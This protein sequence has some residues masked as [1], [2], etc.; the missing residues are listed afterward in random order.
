[1]TRPA[2]LL[3]GTLYE[4]GRAL[5]LA[6]VVSRQGVTRSGRK[7]RAGPGGARDKWSIAP[8]GGFVAPCV[9][10]F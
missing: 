3:D 2:S 9:P 8:T 6:E 7:T 4:N 5:R 10:L 1:M